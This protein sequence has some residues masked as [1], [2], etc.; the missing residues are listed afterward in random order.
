[1]P[2]RTVSLSIRIASA[3]G[4]APLVEGGDS[5]PTDNST[6]KTPRDH[7]T[8]LG[9]RSYALAP[10]KSTRAFDFKAGDWK[11]GSKAAMDFD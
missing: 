4:W 3:P 10:L 6:H 9:I 8:T 7:L 2:D 1:M 5:W 11:P